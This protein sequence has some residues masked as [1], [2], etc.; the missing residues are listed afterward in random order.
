MK[1]YQLSIRIAPGDWP[2]TRLK[3]R[4]KA[5]CEEYPNRCDAMSTVIF[6]DDNQRTA[7]CIRTSVAYRNGGMPMVV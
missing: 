7:R 2:V 6:S 3:A 4:L 5:A 1:Q